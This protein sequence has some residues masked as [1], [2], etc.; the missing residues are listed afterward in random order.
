MTSITN[1][2]DIVTAYAKANGISMNDV[3]S[4]I[5]SNE[6]FPKGKR[7]RPRK[8]LMGSQEPE[9]KRPRGRP[10]TGAVWS[11]DQEMYLTDSGD[12]YQKTEKVA[13]TKPRG[14]PRK[15]I[16]VEEVEVVEVKCGNDVVKVVEST[17]PKGRKP[18]GTTWDETRGYYV[19]E[20]GE[21]YQKVVSTKP[22][23][24]A[25]KGKVWSEADGEYVDSE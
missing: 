4:E 5:K 19:T 20:S 23:G 7:G 10:P 25:P 15:V 8:K 11:D 12:E 16:E 17:K 13:S 24:R 1:I 14:R 22:K 18:K 9:S 2:M 3:M 21:K 6:N